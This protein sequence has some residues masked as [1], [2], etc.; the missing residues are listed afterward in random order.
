MSAAGESEVLTEILIRPRLKI[1]QI[2]SIGQA[3]PPGFWYDQLWDEWVTVL[4][5][6]ARL[7]FENEPHDRHLGPGD[8]VFI[9]ARAP[10]RGMDERQSADNMACRS[11]Q[12]VRP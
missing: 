1:E 5:G 12:A 9:P 6:A 3:S 2:V 8:H 7:R 10:P 11:Q 4:S